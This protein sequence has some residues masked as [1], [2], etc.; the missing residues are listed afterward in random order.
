MP[1]VVLC[2]ALDDGPR[3]FGRLADA[4]GEPAVG[5]R[6]RTIVE[7]FASG[8]HTIAFIADPPQPSSSQRSASA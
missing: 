8:Q 2:V 3:M 4:D 1:Y 7:R 6:V 5:D